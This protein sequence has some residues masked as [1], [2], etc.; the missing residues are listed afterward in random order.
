[1]NLNRE[2]FKRKYGDISFERVS[3]EE[4]QKIKD[5]RVLEEFGNS[6]EEWFT[7]IKE[8][9]ERTYTVTIEGY[10]SSRELSYGD[11]ITISNEEYMCY[12]K[13]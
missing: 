12:Y 11:V 4:F 9:D 1:M 6:F 2:Y 10:H 7:F 5:M 8:T 13:E 3:K